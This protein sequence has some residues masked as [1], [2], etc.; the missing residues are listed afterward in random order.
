MPNSDL[1]LIA[2]E[3]KS[4]ADSSNHND[5][6]KNFYLLVP[7]LPALVVFNGAWCEPT[8]DADLTEVVS[9]CGLL[10][11]MSEAQFQERYQ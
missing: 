10:L 7:T 11:Y 1:P 8:E 4:L 3:T 2:Q 5:Y 9:D 6:K